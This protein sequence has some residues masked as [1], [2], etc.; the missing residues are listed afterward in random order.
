MSPLVV[1]GGLVERVLDGNACGRRLVAGNDQAEAIVAA[2]IPL[3]TTAGDEIGQ[4]AIG[5]AELAAVS[6]M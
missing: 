5:D 1:P 4:C 3:A 2:L 6:R